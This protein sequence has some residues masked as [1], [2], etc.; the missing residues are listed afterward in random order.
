[1]KAGKISRYLKAL[2]F[3]VV[4][5]SGS[6]QGFGQEF[7]AEGF[8][9]VPWKNDLGRRNDMV[10]HE[11]SKNTA[12]FTRRGE[13]LRL[14]NGDLINL[15]YG[16]YKGQFYLV[17]AQFQGSNDR[18]KIKFVLFKEFGK[19]YKPDEDRPDYVWTKGD[20]TATLMYDNRT[21]TGTLIYTYDPLDREASHPILKGK[22]E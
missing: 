4:L 16:A 17:L 8:R 18:E 10:F 12:Y 19:P 9:G 15:Y 14:G 6:G 7:A 22:A 21:K 2:V 11:K 20:T 3:F 5:A 1:M 13:H